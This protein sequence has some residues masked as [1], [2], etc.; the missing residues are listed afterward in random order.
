MSVQF[1]G[2]KSEVAI[3]QKALASQEPEM[4]SVIGRRRVGKTFLVHNVFEGIID[5]EI[6]GIQK[7]EGN[8]QLRNFAARLREFFPKAIILQPPK[9]WLDAFML[10]IELL[11]Q[12]KVERKL[13]V[14]LDELP[15]LATHKSGFLKGLSFFWNS[16]AV[17][18]NIVVILCG[19]A[20]SWMIRKILKDRGGLHNR[21]TKRIRLQ[22]FNLAETKAYLESRN[23]V[24]DHYQLLHLYMALGG[25][26]HYLKEVE[27]G[28]SVVQN[29][30]R[31]CFSQDGL[32]R[33][34][35]SN[36][37]PALFDFPDYHNAIVRALSTKYS[38]MS[39]T[40][41]LKAADLPDGGRI[42]RVLEELT[43]SG[44]IQPFPSYGKKKKDKLYRLIDEYSL[45]YLRFIE[46]N[47]H[48]SKEAWQALSQTQSYKV[49]SGYAFETICLKHVP[50]IKK[51][52][53][54]SG[55]YSISS[56]FL[57]KA[58]TEE[59]GVQIDLLIDRNDQVIN[60]METRFYNTEFTITKD[61]AAKL[62]EKIRVFQES[63]RT[64]KQLFLTFITTF[65]LK[66]NQHSLGLVSSEIKMDSLFEDV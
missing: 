30:N 58:T 29:I 20:A 59:P 40:E 1:V 17:R 44:F 56:S 36:L 65:G 27:R 49:W 66:E 8:E 62:R 57:K 4:I 18:Q 53:G 39:R 26:P 54:I 48:D 37:Y 11:K 33:D 60:L 2:R 45:F 25:I 13:V 50:Q 19:S 23:I 47:R 24:F 61:Y 41:I 15:W 64:K 31:I 55:I 52:L 43:E 16:W 14:F 42:T 63:T 28:Q 3:L 10:L 38:G 12:K 51:A 22:P 21:V 5:F 32:L 7:A 9:D 35:F 6:A 46:K 34:E